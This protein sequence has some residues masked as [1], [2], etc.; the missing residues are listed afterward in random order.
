MAAATFCG[1][2][3]RNAITLSTAQLVKNQE[4]APGD[5]WR[6]IVTGT[7]SNLVFKAGIIAA[8]GDRHLLLRVGIAFAIIAAAGI[9]LIMFWP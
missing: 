9:A 4:I 6:M 5:G 1:E 8:I 2:P 7:L 3:P